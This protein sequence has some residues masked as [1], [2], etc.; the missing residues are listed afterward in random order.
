VLIQW[1]KGFNGTLLTHSFVK[2]EALDEFE[3]K[4]VLDS[5]VV[6]C[7]RLTNISWFMRALNEP[8]ARMAYVDHSLRINRPIRAK[9]AAT[10]EASDYTGIQRRIK[11][12]LKGEKPKKQLPT[13][14]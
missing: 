14:F 6:Y 7:E 8:I 4:T 10:P 3:L 12:A 9:M 2:D 1:H 5:V 11:S 13:V